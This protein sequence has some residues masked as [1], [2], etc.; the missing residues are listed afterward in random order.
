MESLKEKLKAV[1]VKLKTVK[2]IEIIAGLVIIAIMV[3]IYS[4]V[5]SKGTGKS[6][7]D[8]TET[9]ETSDASVTDNLESRLAS[10]LSEIDG[11]GEVKIMITYS[12]TE[13]LVTATDQNTYTTSTTNGTSTTSTTTSTS[14]PVIVGGGSGSEL[15][16]IQQQMPEIVG[17][18]IVAEGA[19]NIKVRLNLISAA[20][21]ALGVKANSIQI[22]TRRDV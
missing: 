13:R 19:A 17:V 21:T 9:V 7:T 12:A 6:G 15:L 5:T 11:A 18:I 8:A 16:V 14:T 10:I 22:F 2:N 1:L 4:T 3:L 20:T